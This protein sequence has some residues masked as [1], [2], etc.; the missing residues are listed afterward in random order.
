MRRTR[1]SSRRNRRVFTTFSRLIAR[2]WWSKQWFLVHFRELHFPSSRWTESQT[3]RAERRIIPNS[4]TTHRRNQSNKHD[5]G[6]DAWRQHR[7]LLEYRRSPR[8]IRFVDRIHTI[9]LIGR[10]IFRWVYMVQRTI[11]KET[12]DIQVWLLVARDMERRVRRSAT[13]RKKHGPSRNWSVITLEDCTVFT[14]LIHRM[15]S[16]KKLFKN[17]LRKLEVPMPAAIDCKIRERTYKETCRKPDSLKTKYAC[18]SFKTTNLRESV[19]KE[20]YTKTMKTTAGK[21]INSLNH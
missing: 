1:R 9:H 20:L 4:T 16:S 8:P 21:G 14:S 6:C 5:L 12:N 17:A 19:W 13:K 3:V 15:R 2:W 18:A 10:K 7:R 11:D